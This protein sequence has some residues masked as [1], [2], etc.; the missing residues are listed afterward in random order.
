MKLD[1]LAFAV[2]PDDVELGCVGTLAKMIAEGKTVGLIDLTQGELGS[3]GSAETRTREAAA[4]AQILGASVR[5]NLL[6]RDGFFQ[7]DED[8]QLRVIRAIR[9]YQPDI[10]FVNAPSDRHPDH[11]R[12]SKLVRDA[13]FLSGLRRIETFDN[14]VAQPHWRPA[15]TFFYIQDYLLKPDFVVDITNFWE[16]KCAVIAAFESQ[17]YSPNSQYVEQPN[18]APATYIS[19]EGF[20]KYLEARA[21]DMGHTINVELGEGFIS[22]TP[23]S[24]RSPMDLLP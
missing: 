1:V 12:A 20:W 17:F 23:L 6:L 2:H 22:E 14:G 19:T 15:R 8:S 10:L 9:K 21:R 16:K 13:A 5:E 3:R 24:V 18:D 7:Q 4:A 11:G